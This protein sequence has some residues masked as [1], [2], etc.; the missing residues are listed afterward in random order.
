MTTNST[1]EP[2]STL[3][4]EDLLRIKQRV[5]GATV[6]MF[7][8]WIIETEHAIKDIREVCWVRLPK[9]SRHRSRRLTKKLLKRSAEYAVIGDAT[10]F[11]A[12]GVTYAHP[13]VVRALRAVVPERRRDPSDNPLLRGSLGLFA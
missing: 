2:H 11:T 6:P 4:Y 13:S 10:M 8:L 7:P 9:P 12:G 5:S 3:R 1:A